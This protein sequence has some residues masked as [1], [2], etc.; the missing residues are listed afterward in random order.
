VPPLWIPKK[1]I[2]VTEIPVLA[3]GKLDVKA[4]EKIAEATG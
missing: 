4:C 3:S 1:M 2:R